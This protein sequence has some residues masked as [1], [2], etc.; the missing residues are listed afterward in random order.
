MNGGLKRKATERPHLWSSKIGSAP[1]EAVPV[2]AVAA[3]F[4][5]DRSFAVS[6]ERCLCDGQCI[7]VFDQR[8]HIPEIPEQPK[9]IKSD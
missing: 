2:V 9:R 3:S 4:Q 1:K 8:V 7:G 6:H 5:V